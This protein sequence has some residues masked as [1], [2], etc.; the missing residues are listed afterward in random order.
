MHNAAW[1]ILLSR[2]RQA[3][4]MTSKSKTVPAVVRQKDGS[5]WAKGS[6]VDGVQVGY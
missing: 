5:L 1:D 3:P 6:T 4:E 2:D